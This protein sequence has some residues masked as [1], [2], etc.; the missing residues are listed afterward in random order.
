M[1]IIIKQI[2]MKTPIENPASKKQLGWNQ[3]PSRIKESVKG[4]RGNLEYDYEYFGTHEK[5]CLEGCVNDEWSFEAGLWFE[6]FVL[7][8]YDGVYQLSIRTIK[9]IRKM[10]FTVPREFED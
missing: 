5:G 6:N 2:I 10:G 4:K 9:K 3:K 7:V 8:D 1:L